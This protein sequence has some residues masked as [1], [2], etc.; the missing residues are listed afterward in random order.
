RPRGASPSTRVM[1]SFSA[2]VTMALP[3]I[4]GCVRDVSE[5]YGRCRSRPAPTVGGGAST[6]GSGR[7]VA[8][9][10]RSADVAEFRPRRARHREVAHVLDVAQVRLDVLG[11]GPSAP[12]TEPTTRAPA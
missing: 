9:R 6:D 12:R 2:R 11:G 8:P 1:R 7:G 5:A 4:P 3:L 10:V